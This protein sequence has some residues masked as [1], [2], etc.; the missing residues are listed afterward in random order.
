ML[1]SQTHIDK[2]GLSVKLPSAVSKKLKLKEG[3]TVYFVET[4]QGYVLK[5]DTQVKA[6]LQNQLKIMEKGLNKFS[7]V[8]TELA[9]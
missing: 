6:N 1:R 5:A 2:Q 4:A 7:S 8:F 9:K 3:D